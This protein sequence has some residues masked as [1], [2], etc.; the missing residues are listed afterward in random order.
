MGSIRDSGVISWGQR[1]S[2]SPLRYGFS[3]SVRHVTKKGDACS[4]FLGNMTNGAQWHYVL[5]QIA[6]VPCA[7]FEFSGNN[8]AYSD[9]H[10][11]RE[12][13]NFFHETLEDENQA[14]IDT[15]RGIFTEGQNLYPGSGFKSKTHIQVAVRNEECIKG[16]FRVMRP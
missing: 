11:N 6:R 9:S 5:A 8:S 13:A 3:Q 2:P 1:S 14:A 15:V 12:R 4:S 7:S 16:V 10:P